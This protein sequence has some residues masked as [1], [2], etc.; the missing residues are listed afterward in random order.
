MK[1]NRILEISCKLKNCDTEKFTRCS[2]FDYCNLFLRFIHECNFIVR[3][4]AIHDSGTSAHSISP[5]KS[6]SGEKGTNEKRMYFRAR[7]I[8][9]RNVST[10]RRT[11][12]HDDLGGDDEREGGSG[13]VL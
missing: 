7:I 8:S 1:V 12:K 4:I 13:N 3:L 11:K 2:I 9:T 5:S 6:L 10:S